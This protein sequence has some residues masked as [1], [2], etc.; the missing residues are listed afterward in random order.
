MAERGEKLVLSPV[1]VTQ[2]LFRGA[3]FVD[4]GTGPEPANDASLAIGDGLLRVST[5]L[6][7]ERI[8]AV[9]DLHPLAER[10]RLSGMSATVER[11]FYRCSRCDDEHRTVEQREAAERAAVDAVRV[12]HALLAPRQIRQ[13][14]ES[15]GLTTEQ[16]GDLLYGVLRLPA[17]VISLVE[18]VFFDFGS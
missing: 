13:L 4:V 3:L 6:D 1:G 9:Y 7:R 17:R 18:F 11:V 12:E 15:L 5:L 10:W 14:R 8:L 2:H 16:L